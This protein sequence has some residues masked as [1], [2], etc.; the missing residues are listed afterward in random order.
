MFFADDS[1]LYCKANIEEASRVLSM[2]QCFEKASGQ[3]F[4]T[5][6]SSVFFSVNMGTSSK[7]DICEVLG[8]VEAGN[9]STYLGLPNM[10]GRNK[11]AIMGF[12]KDKVT[13]R[14]EGWDGRLIS[15]PGKEVLIKLVAQSLPSYA[16]SVFLLP[17]EITKDIE[18]TISKYWWSSKPNKGRGI[19]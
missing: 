11:Y 1:Y 5:S 8:M 18:R 19:H 17:L 15:K 12:L 16:M 10:L 7:T 14:I 3:R 6:K 9:R 4:N 13:R 2:L